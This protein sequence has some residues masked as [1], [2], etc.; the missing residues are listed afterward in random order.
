MNEQKEKEMCVRKKAQ[1]VCENWTQKSNTEKLNSQRDI[2][3]LSDHL[4]GPHSDDVYIHKLFSY[5]VHDGL[6]GCCC[7]SRCILCDCAAHSLRL[8][9]QRS[10]MSDIHDDKLNTLP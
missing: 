7:W 10:T 2:P 6:Q 8:I 4:E 3:F 1:D 5:F 9:K